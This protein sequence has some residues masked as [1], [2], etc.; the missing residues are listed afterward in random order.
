MKEPNVDARLYRTYF[1]GI[2]DLVSDGRKVDGISFAGSIPPEND[3]LWRAVR[4]LGIKPNLHKRAPGMGEA[5]ATDHL[6]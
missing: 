1:K 4:K 3:L 6:L 2:L 5:D